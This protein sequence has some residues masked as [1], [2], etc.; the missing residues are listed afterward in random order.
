MSDLG[1]ITLKNVHVCFGTLVEIKFRG[2]LWICS[3]LTFGFRRILIA[4]VNY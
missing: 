3:L 1:F 2:L 4:V